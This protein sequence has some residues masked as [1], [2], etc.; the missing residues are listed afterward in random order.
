[1]KNKIKLP[2]VALLFIVSSSFAF[3]AF[4]EEG[5]CKQIKSA[6]EAGG[7]IKGAHKKDG[8]GLFKDCMKKVLDGESVPG[9]TVPAEEIAAC[10]VKKEKRRSAKRP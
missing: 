9:V 8:K 2:L 6:C 4:A 10:K 1:M 7:F 5:P 3:S